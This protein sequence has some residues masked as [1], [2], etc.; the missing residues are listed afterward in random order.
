MAEVMIVPDGAESLGGRKAATRRHVKLPH[1]V[2]I[3]YHSP[4]RLAEIGVSG[5]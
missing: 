2:N 3:E 4:R 5:Q 1:P